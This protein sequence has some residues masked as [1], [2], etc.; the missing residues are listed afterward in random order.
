MSETTSKGTL[1]KG[2]KKVA[3]YYKCSTASIQTLVNNGKLPN[4]RI[5]RNRYFYSNEID[6]ALRDCTNQS[7]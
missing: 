7:E 4:Y 5:G 2:I 6:E 1:L 3:E